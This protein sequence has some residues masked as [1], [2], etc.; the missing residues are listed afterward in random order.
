MTPKSDKNEIIA[1]GGLPD[2]MVAELRDDYVVHDLERATDRDAALRAAATSGAAVTGGNTGIDAA[3][4]AAL[5]ALKLV[6]SFGVG[7]DRVDLKALSQRGIALT[8]TAGVVERCV[9]D[10]ALGLMLSLT[11]RIALADRLMRKGLWP[12]AEI[13]LTTRVTGRRVGI[14]GLGRIGVQVAKRA[15]AFDM[16][17]G[18]HNRK[19]R[20]DM[21]Y[22]YFP[23]LVHLAEWADYLIVACP[24]GGNTHHLVDDEVIGALGPDGV[25][26]NIA[27]GPIVDEKVLLRALQKGHLG[28]AGLDVFENEPAV[29][30]AFLQLDNVVLTPHKAGSTRETWR[31]A[32]ELMRENVTA[33][34]EGRALRTP[35]KF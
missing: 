22:Q 27:R 7:Y 34:F 16:P 35:V 13:G 29:P 14:L 19:Q 20:S 1:I 17:V 2:W 32:F 21:P 28:G 18:Y 3:T 24:G 8:N 12:T 11:R 30:S 23:S 6:A 33:M 25:L 15:V 31:E 10:M 4:V 5:P 26:I 9:A